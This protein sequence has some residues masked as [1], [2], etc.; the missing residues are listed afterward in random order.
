MK[1]L[2]DDPEYS[3]T[4][5]ALRDLMSAEMNRIG[6]KFHPSSYYR[7]NWTKDRII[8]KTKAD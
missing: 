1:N 8:L 4:K 7:D 3:E 5:K 6:D 2:A